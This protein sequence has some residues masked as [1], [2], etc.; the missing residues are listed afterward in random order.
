MTVSER[1][2]QTGRP[3]SLSNINQLQNN[4]LM[5][6]EGRTS[7]IKATATE[8]QS[9]RRAET[10]MKPGWSRRSH[11]AHKTESSL[12]SVASLSCLS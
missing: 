1:V 7:G 8:T 10:L 6:E 2:T 11:A 12:S 9:I 4:Q 5:F 3:C